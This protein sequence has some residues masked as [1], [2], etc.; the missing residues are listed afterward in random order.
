[1]VFSN[2]WVISINE[3]QYTVK[4]P[5]ESFILS[6]NQRN[7][8]CFFNEKICRI[9]DRY[10]VLLHKSKVGEG[11]KHSTH[12]TT[13]NSVKSNVLKTIHIP[14][15]KIH[16]FTLLSICRKYTDKFEVFHNQNHYGILF[17]E[18]RGSSCYCVEKCILV[19]TVNLQVA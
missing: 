15:S 14:W 18:C 16:T 17:P 19:I 1:M 6:M 10:F 11:M 7:W 12:F 8:G 2:N 4:S 13:F 3:R 5:L 9:Y